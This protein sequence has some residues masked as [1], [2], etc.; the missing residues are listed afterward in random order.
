M[1]YFLEFL[2]IDSIDMIY[3]SS[4]AQFIILAIPCYNFK[5]NQLFSYIFNNNIKQIIISYLNSNFLQ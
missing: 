4:S 2:I 1:T 5:N 3:K